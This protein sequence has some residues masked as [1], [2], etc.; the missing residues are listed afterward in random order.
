MTPEFGAAPEAGARE[1]ADGPGALASRTPHVPKFA[2]VRRL[3]PFRRRPGSIRRHYAIM[4]VTVSFLFVST[5]GVTVDMLIEKNVAAEAIGRTQ[6]VATEWSARIRA[7]RIP[8]V[9]PATGG[10]NLI[11]VLDPRGRVVD[12]SRAAHGGRLSMFRPPA[13]N[14]VQSFTQTSR[15]GGPLILTAVRVAP[16]RDSLY[17]YAGLLE[18]YLLS[19]N[20]LEIDTAVCGAVLLLIETWVAWNL[21]GQILRPV[22]SIR[23][24]MAKITSGDLSLRVP[25]PSGDDEVA[26][27]AGAVNDTLARLEIMT[28]RQRRFAS[29]VSHELRTPIAGMRARLEEAVLYPGDTDPRETIKDALS[30]ADHLEAVVDDLLVLSRLRSADPPPRAPVNLGHLVAEVAAS[31]TGRFPVHIEVSPG[32]RTRASRV[33]LIRVVENLLANAQRHAASRITVTVTAADGQAVVTLTD[34]GAGIAPK[35]R[36]RVFD[37]FVRLDD[38]RRRDPKGSGLGLA[39]SREVADAHGGTLRVEDSTKGARFV[40]RL[41]LL[42]DDDVPGGP[43]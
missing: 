2:Q 13:D 23:V 21:G 1:P 26:T 30:T 18:S 3:H 34:D 32:V 24:S 33:Q 20:R 36:E 39:I 40:L 4:F 15:N 28:Q 27:L 8:G 22:E 9:I 17:V 19:D 10:V 41:P 42:P 14:R 25:V 7:G 37:R 11:E 35:D 6:Q 5:L 12:A 43:R 29:D 16:T 31:R 38:A